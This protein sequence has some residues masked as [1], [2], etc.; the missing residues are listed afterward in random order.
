MSQRSPLVMCTVIACSHSQIKLTEPQN[1]IFCPSWDGSGHKQ[2]GG[3]GVLNTNRRACSIKTRLCGFYRNLFSIRSSNIYR[4]NWIFP[5][6]NSV[7]YC[8]EISTM[9]PVS[10]TLINTLYCS[11]IELHGSVTAA[12]YSAPF[13]QY[14]SDSLVKKAGIGRACRTHGESKNFAQLL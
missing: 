2:Y 5:P 3:G 11:V 8:S 14:C 1:R 10:L 12:A 4:R 6:T 13:A 7:I 9:W